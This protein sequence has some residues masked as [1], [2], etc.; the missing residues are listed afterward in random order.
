MEGA[1]LT[2]FHV[3][4]RLPG[5]GPAIV[6]LGLAAMQAPGRGPSPP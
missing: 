2:A 4:D 6:T 1:N 3:L 5:A